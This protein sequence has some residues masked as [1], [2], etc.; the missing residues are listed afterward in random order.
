MSYSNP[1]DRNPNYKQCF[2]LLS[3]QANCSL[4]ERVELYKHKHE[5]HY[6]LLRALF[7]NATIPIRQ[8][9]IKFTDYLSSDLVN[10]SELVSPQV[11][12]PSCG[13]PKGRCNPLPRGNVIL[14]IITS[15]KDQ[16]LSQEKFEVACSTLPFVLQVQKA[17]NDALLLN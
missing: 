12:D 9:F 17:L 3:N 1:F 8:S 6:V 2:S 11:Q 13:Q 16:L 7:N 10:T 4:V 5:H 14:S 15:Y